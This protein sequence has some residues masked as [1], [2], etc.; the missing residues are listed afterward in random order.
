MGGVQPCPGCGKFHAGRPDDAGLKS[1]ATKECWQHDKRRLV[2]SSL[3]HR[4]FKP[5][6]KP[7]W[8]GTSVPRHLI[9]V[10]GRR[11]GPADKDAPAADEV[12]QAQDTECAH[13]RLR[14]RNGDEVL[15]SPGGAPGKRLAARQTRDIAPAMA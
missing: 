11:R 8:R 5:S 7:S 14:L 15:A 9:Q 4:A 13:R 2:T 10:G 3:R 1:R 12:D 6:F